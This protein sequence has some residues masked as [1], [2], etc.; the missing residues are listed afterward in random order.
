[1]KVF[2][3]HSVKDA[4]FV[5]NLAARIKSDGFD[6]W[7]CEISIE[8]GSNWVSEIE[9]GLATADLVLLIWSPDASSSF[10]TRVE[11]TRSSRA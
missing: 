10:A 3:S 11:W 5:T 1:M 8:A 9:T 7:L 4:K 6:P 2:L